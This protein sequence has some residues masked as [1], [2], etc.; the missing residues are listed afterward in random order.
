M[1]LWLAMRATLRNRLIFLCNIAVILGVL[2][3][4]LTMA[5]LRSG[6]HE[7]LIAQLSQPG[8]R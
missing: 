6:L 7:A 3:P 5:G 4:L 1:I 8:G 2:V